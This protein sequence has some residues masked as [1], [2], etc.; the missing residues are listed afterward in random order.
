MG[1]GDSTCFGQS[2]LYWRG[3]LDRYLSVPSRL[4]S[5]K[6]SLLVPSTC[7][8]LLWN[9]VRFKCWSRPFSKDLRAGLHRIDRS[10]TWTFDL[11]KCPGP[12]KPTQAQGFP[13]GPNKPRRL[14]QSTLRLRLLKRWVIASLFVAWQT[15][16]IARE[17]TW[18]R[19]RWKASLRLSFLKF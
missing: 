10:R 7:E 16:T 6:K 8:R 18:C 3:C 5:S 11:T 2:L 4:P 9:Y 17:S 12:N 13:K 15:I 1:H 19:P 14:I